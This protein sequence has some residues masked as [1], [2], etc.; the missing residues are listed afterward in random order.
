VGHAIKAHAL[1]DHH[2]VVHRRVI[3]HDRGVLEDRGGM[4][5]RQISRPPGAHAARRDEDIIRTV[6]AKLKADPHRDVVMIKAVPHDERSA[7]RK[8]SPTTV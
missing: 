7:G 1:V 4:A 8:R 6:Q 5:R 2:V 3:V